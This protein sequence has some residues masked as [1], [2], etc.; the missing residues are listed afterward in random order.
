MKHYLE[1]ECGERTCF[2]KEEATL[3]PHVYTT[4]FGTVWHC[5]IFGPVLEE[6]SGWLLRCGNCLDKVKPVME[7]DS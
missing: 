4:N 5:A 2:S 1:I 7:S 3:C 6:K